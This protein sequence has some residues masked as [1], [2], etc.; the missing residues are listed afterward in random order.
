MHFS[1]MVCEDVESSQPDEPH[2]TSGN[3]LFYL[4]LGFTA[5]KHGNIK[6]GFFS[7]LQLLA[8]VWPAA[9]RRVTM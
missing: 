7:F 3:K 5:Y 6:G 9:S 8:C 1:E 4:L 2:N